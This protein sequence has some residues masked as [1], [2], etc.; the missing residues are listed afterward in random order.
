M[1][2]GAPGVPVASMN[3]VLRWSAMVIGLVTMAA[4][5]GFGYPPEK[6]GYTMSTACFPLLLG[7]YNDD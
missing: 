7:L 3:D 5:I 6:A 2:Q 4:A 1:G